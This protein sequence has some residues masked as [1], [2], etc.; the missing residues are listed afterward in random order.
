MP[1]YSKEAS[2]SATPK[3]PRI[4]REQW[5][6]L[7]RRM[8]NIP[9]EIWDAVYEAVVLVHAPKPENR[10]FAVPT[11]ISLDTLS[12]PDYV[13]PMEI[14]NFRLV[15]KSWK[16]AANKHFYATF[17]HSRTVQIHRTSINNLVSVGKRGH[18]ATQVS[19][20]TFNVDPLWEKVEAK[21]NPGKILTVTEK[22]WFN[23]LLDDSL[24]TALA[25][26]VRAIKA[27]PKLSIIRLRSHVARK[28]GGQ[29]LVGW[30]KQTW[31]KHLPAMRPL[32]MEEVI[33][34]LRQVVQP[35]MTKQPLTLHFDRAHE[36]KWAAV[37]NVLRPGSVQAINNPLTQHLRQLAVI[38]VDQA[39]SVTGL[40]LWLRMLCPYA[41][42]LQL[43][44][45]HNK[46]A[47]AAINNGRPFPVHFPSRFPLQALRH[48][49]L[50]DV[51]ANDR[52]LIEILHHLAET[53]NTRMSNRRLE[54]VTFQDCCLGSIKHT[55][56]EIWKGL[57]QGW[58]SCPVI[59][60]RG[61]LRYAVNPESWAGTGD[62]D[63]AP[64]IDWAK[65][66]SPELQSITWE[67]STIDE[68]NSQ[69]RTQI[70]D[71]E[72]S[73]FDRLTNS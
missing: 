14:L 7:G 49:M 60:L 57:F 72:G 4:P 26:V 9:Q 25:Q 10:D 18:L 24:H 50:K 42:N 40:T 65:S 41:V 52:Q 43:T 36:K 27:F 55:D 8:A 34:L 22:I 62:V 51:C 31:P 37:L 13:V 2:R 17:F 1:R 61:S 45:S 66:T 6:S 67:P 70:I 39:S 71:F 53:L 56:Q 19:S 12:H 5:E 68:V 35:G 59:K 20:L 54:S 3:R 21:D 58:I 15:C 73:D 48:L 32:A 38:R 23:L 47:D 44:F 28:T 30:R 29:N 11:P 69:S 33:K 63:I 16:A 64:L 46:P